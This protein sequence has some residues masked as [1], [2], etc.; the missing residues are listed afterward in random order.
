MNIPNH[1][2]LEALKHMPVGEIAVL[3]AAELARLQQE[4]TK[5]L[6]SSKMACE[7]LDGALALKYAD[8]ADDL[9]RSAQKDPGTVRFADGEI[10]V[11]ADL[12]KRVAWDQTQLARMV[13]RIRAAGDDPA[14]IIDISYKVAAEFAASERK[15]WFNALVDGLNRL[16]RPAMAFGTIWLFSFAMRDPVGFAERMVGLS[17]I[18]DPLW[19]LLGAVVSFYFGARELNYMRAAKAP[20]VQQVREIV[21]STEAIRALRPDSPRVAADETELEHGQG[22]NAALDEW[23]RGV[24]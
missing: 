8:Q 15:G 9:R 21:Q 6:R 7:W 19:W 4:T 20:T 24:V 16:P 5:A 14:E 18:P 12:P 11:K 3:P 17:A 13:E 22:G 23:R 10:T 2:T 1:I